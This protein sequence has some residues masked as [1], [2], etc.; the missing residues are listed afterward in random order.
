[1][2]VEVGERGFIPLEARAALKRNP[3]TA[4][5]Q[6]LLLRGP[7]G[8]WD[9]LALA[10]R[11]AARAVG[12]HGIVWVCIQHPASKVRERLGAGGDPEFT[13]VDAVSR[14]AGL[15]EEP[16]VLYCDSPS[17]LHS[18]LS[19]LH[20]L[21][22]QGPRVVVWDSLNAVLP[23]A[24]PDALLRAM[25]TVNA[26]VHESGSA[27]LYYLVEGSVDPAAARALEGAVDRVEAAR[28]PATW[29]QVLSLERPLL[30]VALTA[31]AAINAGLTMVLLRFVP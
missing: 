23:Y 8:T 22:R 2:T 15:P 31:M 6:A 12:A 30:Y 10:A 26:R 18:I 1:M 16:R 17:A 29:R 27:V 4:P 20:P 5:G 14:A 19:L 21:L 3:H 24:A 28:G 7:A 11:R 13:F 9:S 25:A